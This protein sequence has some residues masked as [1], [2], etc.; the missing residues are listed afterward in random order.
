MHV[1]E[2][3]SVHSTCMH[4]YVHI[5]V[6]TFKSKFEYLLSCYM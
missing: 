2:N 3:Y 6:T 4:V 5:H 1:H